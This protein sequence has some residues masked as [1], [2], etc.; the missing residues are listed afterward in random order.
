VRRFTADL[1]AV[2]EP[3][4]WGFGGALAL[5]IIL[6]AG[7]LA[8][9]AW[10]GAPPSGPSRSSGLNCVT[11][12]FWPAS[13]ARRGTY[14]PGRGPPG[15]KTSSA[16]RSRQGGIAN[17]TLYKTANFDLYG[18][19]FRWVSDFEV[20]TSSHHNPPDFYYFERQVWGV[21]VGRIAGYDHRR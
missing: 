3:A 6:I 2:G 10:N 19:D 12:R 18:D 1:S 15:P 8:M 13:P 5:G 20:A 7:F 21:F 11:A 9:I 14:R 4:L 16:P 17:R